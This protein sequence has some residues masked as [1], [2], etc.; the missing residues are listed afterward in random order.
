MRKIKLIF[1]LLIFANFGF[2][3]YNDNL[4]TIENRQYFINIE[5]AYASIGTLHSRKG[6][7]QVLAW[8]HCGAGKYKG[9]VYAKA[10]GNLKIQKFFPEKDE[11]I[12]NLSGLGGVQL[13]VDWVKKTKTDVHN[14]FGVYGS[15][16]GSGAKTI[17]R[18]DYYN[19][20]FKGHNAI[21]GINNTTYSKYGTYL[22][23]LAQYS[24]NINYRASLGR[25]GKIRYSPRS[26]FDMHSFFI[27]AEV[28]RPFNISRKCCEF[29]KGWLIEPQAQ[30]IYN[31]TVGKKPEQLLRSF[32]YGDNYE[33]YYMHNLRARA[34]LRLA[35]NS[36]TDTL[37]TYTIYGYTNLWGDYTYIPS[38]DEYYIHHEFKLWTELGAGG[39]IPIKKDIYVY[40]DAGIQIPLHGQG[41]TG[42]KTNLGI[43]H[44]F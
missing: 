39:Q 32:S 44:N 22:D 4:H 19:E 16:V 21:I 37:N 10:I 35:H 7:N 43:K 9:M 3:D 11:E 25:D 26:K 8:D 28:G 13:G 2:A 17:R 1:A 18:N 5:N 38:E 14:L 23:I 40:G 36:G 30:I 34:G 27:S 41:H 31:F 6:E 20:K 29:Q 15:Y 24:L 33:T 12:N 42:F